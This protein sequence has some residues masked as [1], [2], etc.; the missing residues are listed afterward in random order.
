MLTGP[1][2]LI[3]EARCSSGPKGHKRFAGAV[4]PCH[5]PH[6]LAL[7]RAHYLKPLQ[8]AKKAET[9]LLKEGP[10]HKMSLF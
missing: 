6:F 1:P 8:K 7:V 9:R 10:F 2:G 5:Y 4:R 3:P